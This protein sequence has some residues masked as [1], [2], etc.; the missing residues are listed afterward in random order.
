MGYG[1]LSEWTWYVGC[2]D[3]QITVAMFTR[4]IG[5]D[6]G[7]QSEDVRAAGNGFQAARSNA[8]AAKV[9]LQTE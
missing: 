8:A 9:F 1:L 7:F 4:C 5:V 3:A 2:G 6:Q